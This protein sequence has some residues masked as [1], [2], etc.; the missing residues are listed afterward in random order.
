MTGGR[1]SE[2]IS[3]GSPVEASGGGGGCRDVGVQGPLQLLA[4][5]EVLAGV[6]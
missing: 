2:G 4:G 5:Q 6:D 3:E 1:Y